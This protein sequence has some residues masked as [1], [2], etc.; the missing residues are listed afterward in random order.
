VDAK[1]NVN[2]ARLGQNP[3]FGLTMDVD[4][5]GLVACHDPDEVLI[6]DPLNLTVVRT[7]F[8]GYPLHAVRDI[9]ID[10]N[11]DYFVS[12]SG[13]NGVLR[14]TPDGRIFTVRLDTFRMESPSGGLSI[15]V[16][17]G[18][19]LV[20]DVAYDD[21]LLRLHR[22]GTRLEVLGTGFNGRYGSTQHIP[23]GEVF[24]GSGGGRDGSIHHLRPYLNKAEIFATY[25]TG[26]TAMFAL[27]MDR[28]SPMEQRLI[29]TGSGQSGG[30]WYVDLV[31]T[32]VQNFALFG[33]NAFEI[34][35]L[36]GRNLQT[37]RRGQGLYDVK[38]SFPEA[39]TRFFTLAASLRGP[40]PAMM[41][42]DGRT[43]N[44]GLDSLV[45]HTLQQELA[46]YLTGN[47]GTLDLA[48]GATAHLD[49]RGLGPHLN[50]TRI[51]LAALV[52][53]PAASLGIHT[54]SDPYPFV[55]E[56]L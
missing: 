36:Q 47:H 17:T 8:K 41:I 5:R 50:G 30:I 2:A 53:D 51:W 29:G 15:D 38:L 52:L 45:L 44:L 54:I 39:R 31:T 46:P 33:Q 19:L 55:V 10:H 56:G 34:E 23:T 27:K 18:E 9:T 13:L 28:A 32:A 37:I 25:T 35:F 26:P 22:D 42:P 4:N 48:G 14:I 21:A 40:R 11:G 49:L 3:F 12:D 16:N 43:L 24:A 7:L 6:I 1:G 20:L